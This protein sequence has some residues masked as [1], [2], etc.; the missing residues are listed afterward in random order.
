[1]GID[2]GDDS[3]GRKPSTMIAEFERIR[4]C[5]AGSAE[6]DELESK[7]I[8]CLAQKHLA[9][10]MI[11]N[12]IRGCKGRGIRGTVGRVSAFKP[13][14]PLALMST[15]SLREVMG[16]IEHG[17]VL[18][19]KRRRGEEERGRERR[20]EGWLYDFTNCVSFSCMERFIFTTVTTSLA[21]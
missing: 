9:M 18:K 16:M 13:H 7:L 12:M 6:V 2:N 3:S 19:E 14:R 15:L 4:R 1:M 17:G 20:V 10:G 21:A 8:R 5:L 11:M